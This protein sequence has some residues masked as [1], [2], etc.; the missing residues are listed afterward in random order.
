MLME[1]TTIEIAARNTE[2]TFST[3]ISPE[4]LILIKRGF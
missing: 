2:G 4:D 1:E 3:A